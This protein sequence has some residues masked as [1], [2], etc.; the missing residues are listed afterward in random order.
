MKNIRLCFVLIYSLLWLA[1]CQSPTQVP[2]TE[3]LPNPV[4]SLEAEP[5]EKEEPP[6]QP[7]E[8]GSELAVAALQKGGCG[9]CHVIP[10]VPGAAGTIGPDLSAI[11]EVVEAR[12]ESGEYSGAAKSTQEYFLEALN[13]PDAFISPDCGGKPCS[14]G[15]MPASLA[16][17]LSASELQ[18][19]VGYMEDLPD[20]EPAPRVGDLR[21]SRI[22]PPL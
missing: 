9:A 2:P 6:E 16:Q 1:A 11:G 17:A 20:R 13:A 14:P 18:A 5:P 8:G 22:F 7:S 21:R 10:G 12:L 19:V 4:E 15:L 3:A